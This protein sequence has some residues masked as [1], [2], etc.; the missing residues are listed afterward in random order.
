MKTKV[1]ICKCGHEK[2]HHDHGE[3]PCAICA[4]T[5]PLGTEPCPK[6][7]AKG[8]AGVREVARAAANGHL[9]HAQPAPSRTPRS[10]IGRAIDDI[11]RALVVIRDE[12]ER[13]RETRHVKTFPDGS[14]LVL[15]PVTVTHTGAPVVRPT[16]MEKPAQATDD[17]GGGSSK[18]ERAFLTAL[19]QHPEGLSRAQVLMHTSYAR[20]GSTNK[21]FGALVRNGH[22]EN[23]AAGLRITDKG[24]AHLG[25][26]N[27][28]PKGAALLRYLLESNKLS[29]AERILLEAAHLAGKD[30]WH[31][32][33]QLLDACGYAR[34]GSTNKAF[35]KLVRYGYLLKQ[36]GKVSAWGGLFG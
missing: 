4:G 2:D 22:V 29:T 27:A 17:D 12:L 18:A 7:R 35:G 24:R 28:L 34:S 23:C 33:Q 30:V 10:P 16:R 21:V 26:F 11:I 20:S 13:P 9:V 8:T 15:E 6:F 3:G 25:P 31:T 19:A 5:N 32:R 14:R 1:R 36:G